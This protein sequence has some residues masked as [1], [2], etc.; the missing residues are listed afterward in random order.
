MSSVLLFNLL[1]SLS[2]SMYWIIPWLWKLCSDEPYSAIQSWILTA[3]PYRSFPGCGVRRD[4]LYSSV[5][6]WILIAFP[7]PRSFPGCGVGRDEPYFAIQTWRNPRNR[8]QHRYPQSTCLSLNI[9]FKGTVQRDGS[10]RNK[11][12]SIDLFEWKC[13]GGFLEKSARPPSSESPSKY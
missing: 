6:S 4:E 11:A 10:S 1:D 5:Q 8:I 7:Y 12:H 9:C 2:S 13:R 3:L